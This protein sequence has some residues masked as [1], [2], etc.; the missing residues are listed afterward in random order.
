MN[1]AVFQ[2]TMENRRKH[3]DIK[4]EQPNQEGIIQYQNQTTIQQIVF[5]K[6]FYPYKCKKTHIFINKLVYL[7]LSIL[8]IS[9]IVMYEFFYVYVK[10]NMVKKQNYIIQIQIALQLLYSLHKNRSIYV[11]ISKYIE[12]IID[13]LYSELDRPLLI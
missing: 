5:R 4:L 7:G 6:M 11:D 8:E 12:A 9:K 2:K 13:T 1:K 3:R 10:T